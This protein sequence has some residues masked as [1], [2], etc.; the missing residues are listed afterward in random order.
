LASLERDRI[1][2]PRPVA[3][4]EVP[5]VD[6][7]EE[8]AVLKEAV[9]GAVHGEGGLVFVHGEA[10]IEKTRLLREVGAYARS[11]GV[12][13]PYGRCSALFRMDGVPRYTIWKEVIKDH[14]GEWIPE[15]LYRVVGFY[16][17]EVAKLAPELIQK[18]RTI[19]QSL[20]IRPVQVQKASAIGALLCMIAERGE[21]TTSELHREVRSEG[22]F[23]EG[24]LVTI[25]LSLAKWQIIEF[26]RKHTGH[27]TLSSGRRSFN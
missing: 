6:R 12:K 17:A 1:P 19:P 10:G 5:L 13:V 9:Y 20:P 7:V 3:A 4:R 21:I 16:L 22:I 24:D 23:D 27:L 2:S 14:L 18:L 8:T 26:P 15:Q 11:R 25:L